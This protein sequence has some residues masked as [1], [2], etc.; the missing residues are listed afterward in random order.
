MPAAPAPSTSRAGRGLPGC[1]LKAAACMRVTHGSVWSERALW[2]PPQGSHLC[3]VQN[4]SRCWGSAKFLFL[5]FFSFLL[6]SLAV[7]EKEV[8][9]W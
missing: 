3:E 6:F 5:F 2:H 8:Q 7:T 4:T 9:Q 1:A